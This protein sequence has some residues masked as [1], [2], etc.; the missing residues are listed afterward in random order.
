MRLVKNL[1]VNCAALCALLFSN[2]ALAS[3]SYNAT[4][5]PETAQVVTWENGTAL[6][7][8]SQAQSKLSFKFLHYDAGK[9]FFLGTVRRHNIWPG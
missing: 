8:S 6:I 5:M 7:E 4:P 9:L 2:V 1:F 3:T